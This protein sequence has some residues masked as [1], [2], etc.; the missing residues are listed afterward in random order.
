M[1]TQL[2]RRLTNKGM[3]WCSHERLRDEKQSWGAM[4]KISS[5]QEPKSHSDEIETEHPFGESKKSSLKVSF[6][7]DSR[8]RGRT[9]LVHSNLWSTPRPGAPGS[10]HLPLL[11]LN[12]H[13]PTGSSPSSPAPAPERRCSER[14]LTTRPPGS[15]FCSP[16]R[17]VRQAR[18]S[19]SGLGSFGLRDSVRPGSLGLPGLGSSSG[20]GPRQGFQL[21]RFPV[22][23]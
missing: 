5:L 3:S 21:P 10:R 16:A 20:L 14:P 9:F 22:H 4:L 2:L 12:A 1:S 6:R 8:P 19:V 15:A 7:L 18:G 13:S 17:P 11:G 23:A